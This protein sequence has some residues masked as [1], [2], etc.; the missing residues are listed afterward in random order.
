M[1]DRRQIAAKL[2]RHKSFI[3]GFYVNVLLW[4]KPVLSTLFNGGMV[5]MYWLYMNSHSIISFLG[6]C[7]IMFMG[8]DIVTSK[9][10]NLPTLKKE[11]MTLK[12]GHLFPM[13]GESPRFE[14]CIE[15]IYQ[16]YRIG[17]GL[18][19]IAIR[20]YELCHQS[21]YHAAAQCFVFSM[22]FWGTLYLFH[23]MFLTT[24]AT[25]ILLQLPAIRYYKLFSYVRQHLLSYVQAL[26]NKVLSRQDVARWIDDLKQHMKENSEI[27]LSGFTPLNAEEEITQDISAAAS[28]SNATPLAAI[29]STAD[30]VEEIYQYEMLN[31]LVNSARAVANS[32]FPD[33][34]ITPNEGGNANGTEA[35]NVDHI[36]RIL[37]ELSN[38]S[39]N[40]QTGSNTVDSYLD[41]NDFELVNLDDDSE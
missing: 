15:V 6:S 2:E 7:G 23:K 18:R 26:I 11:I 37:E 27:D 1:L 33:D 12:G 36:D 16:A 19:V 32:E 9:F 17:H 3:M 30:L 24:I 4:K 28:T 8:Y 38:P 40:T 35:N 41:L 14:D 25:L 34:T 20:F 39:L 13:Q 31:L 29:P 21:L 10:P 22:I 5:G